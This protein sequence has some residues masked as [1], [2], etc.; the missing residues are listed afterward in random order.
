M[1]GLVAMIFIHRDADLELS[2]ETFLDGA[3]FI[4]SSPN[5]ANKKQS[6]FWFRKRNFGL[7][8]KVELIKVVIN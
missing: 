6:S 2:N 5:F 7:L 1:N 4:L 8:I 3:C